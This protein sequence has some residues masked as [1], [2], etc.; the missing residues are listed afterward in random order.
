MGEK[1]S[2]ALAS[3]NGY[4]AS[5]AGT[6]YPRVY[7]IITEVDRTTETERLTYTF[8]GRRI[9]DAVHFDVLEDIDP[10]KY[11]PCQACSHGA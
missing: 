7:H 5:T 10:H 9:K 4:C 3:K 8:C 11:Q 1:M 6:N 2:S